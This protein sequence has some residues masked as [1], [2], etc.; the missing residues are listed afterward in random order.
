MRNYEMKP[1]S[2]KSIPSAKPNPTT[3]RKI[4][5]KHLVEGSWDDVSEEAVRV[6]EAANPSALSDDG[7]EPPIVNTQD[8]MEL[9]SQDTK[10]ASAPITI[11]KQ[12]DND[13]SLGK[14]KHGQPETIMSRPKRDMKTH[15]AYLTF[16]VLPPQQD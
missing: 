1:V 15:T 6:Y 11:A 16:G 9:D 2:F 14:R 7:A 13:G 3:R 10:D 12:P 4:N 5:P 8:A